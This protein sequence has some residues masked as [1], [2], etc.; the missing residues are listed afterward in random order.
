MR[1]QQFQPPPQQPPPNGQRGHMDAL[2]QRFSGGF[3]TPQ[4]QYR[5]Q[6]QQQYLS[7]GQQQYSPQVQQQQYN[8][9]V[10]QQYLAPGQQQ[11]NPQVQ[12]PQH[13]PV[14]QFYNP[15]D[16]AV[17]SD[18]QISA[19]EQGG[20]RSPQEVEPPL[21]GEIE[22]TKDGDLAI[23]I[24][25]GTTYSVVG[26]FRDGKVEI[27][28]N[29][30]GNRTTPSCVAFTPEGERLVGE[31]AKSQAASNAQRTV[32]DAKRLIGRKFSDTEVQD[33][34]KHW[35]F[36]VVENEKGNP[37]IRIGTDDNDTR[38][39]APEEISAMVLGKLKQTAERYLNQ[40]VTR[41][42]ITCPAYFNDSQRQATIDAATIAGLDVLRIINEPTAA[43]IAYGLNSTRG[44]G[45]GA[46]I[47]VFDL[48]GGT[49]DVSF[50]N[51]AHGVFTVKATGGNCH[52]GGC[53][54]DNS[55]LK[56]ALEKFKA[57]TPL[58][59]KAMR[60][61]LTACEQAKRTLSATQSTVI[62]VDALHQGEDLRVE[63]T[64]SQFEMLN[65]HLF[66]ACLETVRDVLRDGGVDRADIDDVVFV[67]G[68]SRIPR[69]QEMI[70]AFFK[71]KKPNI[72]INP[73]ECVAYGAAIQASILA[74]HHG[75]LG[76][77]VLLVDVAP[78]SL[79]VETAG[80][81]MS[82]LIPRNTTIPC[83]KT[84]MFSTYRDSQ[85]SVL[86][87]IFEGE[88][89][90]CSDNNLLGNFYLN[91]I[92]P[93]KAGVP[94]IQVTFEMDVN[95]V[96]HVSAEDQATQNQSHISIE[97]E[98]GRLSKERIEE[99]VAEAARH[100]EADQK[101]MEQIEARNAL[102][103][104]LF[105]LKQTLVSQEVME[106]VP[107]DQRNQIDTLLNQQLEW[108]N[109]DGKLAT[110]EQ[111]DAQK[112]RIEKALA[113]ILGKLYETT[114]ELP[115]QE[116]AKLVAGPDGLEGI[117]KTGMQVSARE[118]ST[119]PPITDVNL[120][121][122]GPPYGNASAPGTLVIGPP[123]AVATNVEAIGPSIIL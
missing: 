67:G 47:L 51:L 102:E 63:V 40:P 16:T 23:G 91:D 111:H 72:S 44:G 8:P 4:V 92:Q 9:Q 1:V 122:L 7:P 43:S 6:V 71:G 110:K 109:G 46:N 119:A 20:P 56:F 68:S 75:N 112:Q 3:Q 28:T 83:L 81:A 39:F 48:G 120:T 108:I 62:E 18:Q 55:L 100:Q 107:L 88:R 41:A 5:P 53:D 84:N 74:G 21:P 98:T 26:V 37:L 118:G 52:L 22:K 45:G 106:K 24:D 76:S 19:P 14:A 93:A 79:G 116:D 54:F 97:S 114:G 70:T 117:D 89:A 49:M 113:P 94:K 38:D 50:L 77:E 115:G 25:L 57:D 59:E 30:H 95:G 2:L 80:G 60:R 65:A 121:N 86:V 103:R 58:S 73:D 78:L 96:L 13:P 34:M 29:E 12:Q 66:D 85:E 17:F 64:R 99:L 61:L 69:L 104:F 33:D 123:P 15:P 82:V 35:P 11:Y 87:S 27:I 36:Q 90:L 42:V 31:S 105:Q 32:F 10:Q 101:K